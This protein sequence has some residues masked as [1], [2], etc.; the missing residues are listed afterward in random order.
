MYSSF[1]FRCLKLIA[2]FK[3]KTIIFVNVFGILIP[4]VYEVGE[5]NNVK[6]YF[7]L[8]LLRM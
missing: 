1:W 7:W 6:R 2:Y 4:I 8:R 3:N 5:D